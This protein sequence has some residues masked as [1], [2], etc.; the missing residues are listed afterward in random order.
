MT[1]CGAKLYVRWCHFVPNLVSKWPTIQYVYKYIRLATVRSERAPGRRKTDLPLY[2]LPFLSPCW[3][4]NIA[5][6]LS[7]YCN[8]IF[9]QP[10]QNWFMSPAQ[11]IL[12]RAVITC[13]R[14]SC[15]KPHQHIPEPFFAALK[16]FT[17]VLAN[18]QQWLHDTGQIAHIV[19]HQTHTQR[20]KCE[21]SWLSS[22]AAPCKGRT[23]A[24]GV[25]ILLL[26]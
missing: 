18:Y 21:S 24:Q 4:L 2:Q 12:F 5:N 3:I 15:R 23:G 7:C 6:F 26:T 11:M 1:P 20:R 22:M 25:Y 17:C 19:S 14:R 9:M 10:Y 16:P 13:T 8:A